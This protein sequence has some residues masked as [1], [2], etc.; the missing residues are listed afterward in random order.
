MGQF[1]LPCCILNMVL[2]QYSHVSEHCTLTVIL[3]VL[4]Y[5]DIFSSVSEW[6]SR[7]YLV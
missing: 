5:D 3:P 4:Q 1:L 7:G 2:Y 6:L